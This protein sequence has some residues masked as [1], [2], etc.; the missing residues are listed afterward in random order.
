MET[1]IRVSASKVRNIISTG[2]PAYRGRFVNVVF[3][4]SVYLS[5][6]N[7]DGGVKSEYTF[8]QADMTGNRVPDLV[9]WDNPMEGAKVT[10]D[11]SFLVVVHHFY[12]GKES[13]TIHAHPSYSPKWLTA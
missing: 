9:P 1:T 10:L 5:H 11:P 6:L 2:A 7:W 12:W 13:C 4:E 3:G 8:V